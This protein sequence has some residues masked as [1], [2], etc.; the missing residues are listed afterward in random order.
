MLIHLAIIVSR[1]L[2]AHAKIIWAVIL[3]AEKNM[4]K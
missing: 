2:T 4:I 3:G 1:I